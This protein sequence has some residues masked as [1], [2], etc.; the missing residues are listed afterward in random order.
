MP[1]LLLTFYLVRSRTS[2]IWTYYPMVARESLSRL[3][4]ATNLPINFGENSF[5]WRS[6]YPQSKKVSRTTTRSDI[7]AYNNK[8]RIALIFEIGSCNFF[9]LLTFDIWNGGAHEDYLSVVA[10]YL[11]SKWILRK[12]IIGLVDTRHTA[13]TICEHVLSVL[14]EYSIC[15]LII[16]I[17]LDNAT[18]NK[19]RLMIFKFW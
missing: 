8:V 2:H 4:A 18:V 12:R 11:D 9:I 15:N 5:L 19:K 3:I 16:S 17:T 13:N 6:Y 10:Y 1:Y 14:E 7:I